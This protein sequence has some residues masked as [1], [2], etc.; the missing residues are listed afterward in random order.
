MEQ[1]LLDSGRRAEIT[2]LVVDE[3]ARGQGV[4]RRLVEGVEAWATGR[5]LGVL[6]VR[7]NVMRSESHPFYERMGFARVKTQHA[8]RKQ[9]SQ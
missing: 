3:S 1:E 8:Y 6:A 7:S 4:G 9:L 5:G 2:G